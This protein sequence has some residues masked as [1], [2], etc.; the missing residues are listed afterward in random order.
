M[1]GGGGEARVGIEGDVGKHD[2][3]VISLIFR[4]SGT[5]KHTLAELQLFQIYLVMDNRWYWD[6]SDNVLCAIVEFLTK[7]SYVHSTLKSNE[8]RRRKLE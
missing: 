3:K 6:S 7:L 5:L 2:K 8:S 1:G 4:L